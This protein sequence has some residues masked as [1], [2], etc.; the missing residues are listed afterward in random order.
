LYAL[1]IDTCYAVDCIN[2]FLHNSGARFIF[3]LKTGVFSAL[4][5]RAYKIVGLKNLFCI[6]LEGGR[7][8]VHFV[9]G[10]DDHRLLP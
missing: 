5:P 8:K 2:S 4:A 9:G 1:S 3:G 7:A 6:L 10:I